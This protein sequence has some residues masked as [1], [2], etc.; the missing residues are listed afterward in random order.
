[1]NEYTPVIKQ[2]DKNGRWYWSTYDKD[3][4]LLCVGHPRGYETQVLANIAATSVMRRQW[5]RA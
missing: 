3:G 2:S 5:V 1:M 4:V